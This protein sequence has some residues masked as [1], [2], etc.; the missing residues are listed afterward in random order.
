MRTRTAAAAIVTFVDLCGSAQARDFRVHTCTTPDDRALGSTIDQLQ[1]PSGWVWSHT[2]FLQPVLTDGCAVSNAFYYL[3]GSGQTMSGGQSIWARWTAAPG[4]HL[5]RVTARWGAATQLNAA[6]GEGSGQ[7]V[8]ATDQATLLGVGSPS[9]FAYGYSNVPPFTASLSP[10]QWFEIRF[11]CLDR[12]STT[13]EMVRVRVTVASFD[14]DDSAPPTG[15][16]LGTATDAQT[17]SGHM[18]FGLNAVRCRRR[19][20]QD[21]GRGRRCGRP[22]DPP[23]R[24]GGLLPRHRAGSCCRRVRRGSAVPSPYRQRLSRHRHDEAAAG[25]AHGARAARGRPGE[26]H[27]PDDRPVDRRRG[28]WGDRAGV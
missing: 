17:W 2:G 16:L 20:R 28:G 12:C 18:Q 25:A 27:P 26:S 4:T 10:A 24:P 8:V 11:T 19:R 22:D 14:V 13:T 9:D 15:G 23:R 21:C 7:L 6:R 3:I 1:L 5:R